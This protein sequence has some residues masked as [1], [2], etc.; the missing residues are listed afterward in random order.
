M[1]K[2]YISCSPPLPM[3][4]QKK[5]NDDNQY[6]KTVTKA[7]TLLLIPCSYSYSLN[8]HF[9]YMLVINDIRSA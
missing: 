6:Y 1:K 3:I 5:F 7:E 2:H 4:K 8:V 9:V